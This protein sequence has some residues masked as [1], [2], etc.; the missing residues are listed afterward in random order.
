[1]KFLFKKPLKY[2]EKRKKP[3]KIRAKK[4]SATKKNQMSRASLT[5]KKKRAVNTDRERNASTLLH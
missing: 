4:S 5:F 1:M 3:T 2:H